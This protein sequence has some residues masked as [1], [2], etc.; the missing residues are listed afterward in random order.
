MR[1][2][3]IP[4]SLA[5]LVA[6]IIGM[7]SFGFAVLALQSD[8]AAAC[9]KTIP[10]TARCFVSGLLVGLGLLVMLP[11]A[12][13]QRPPGDAVVDVLL[14]FCVAPVAMFFVHHV[15]LDH[16]HLDP[17]DC[18][19]PKG[20][21]TITVVGKDGV[22]FTRGTLQFNKMPAF[23]VQSGTAPNPSLQAAPSVERSLCQLD[24]V[25]CLDC[26]ALVETALPDDC[27]DAVATCMSVLLRALPYAVHSCLDGAVLATATS[28]RMLASL[29]LPIALCAVQDVG[30]I[31]VTLAASSASR[32]AKLIVTGCFGLGFPV[33]TSLAVTLD[34]LG[35]APPGLLIHLRAFAA[36]LFVYMALFELAPTRVHT[37]DRR[38]HLYFVLAFVAGLAIVRISE[39]AEA[40]TGHSVGATAVVSMGVENLNDDVG[41]VSTAA[42]HANESQTPARSTM[43]LRTPW[44][45][46][47]PAAARRGAWVDGVVERRQIARPGAAGVLLPEPVQAT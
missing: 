43:G 45:A 11:L 19:G 41:L 18:G 14:T 36:G 7:A 32:R 46:P 31:L 1:T 27:R 39:A 47:P 33:G 34:L 35:N 29:A 4:P 37:H 21:G 9:L 24:S 44:R 23:C 30:T 6:A 26:T 2:T 5:T 13:E 12:L 3:I 42:T 28:L 17:S 10:P 15:L 22:A 40:G 8:K 20:C 38:T 25:R 16:R